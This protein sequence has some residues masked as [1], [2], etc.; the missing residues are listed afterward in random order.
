MC[1]LAFQVILTLISEYLQLWYFLKIQPCFAT[2]EPAYWYWCCFLS[3]SSEL[4][5]IANSLILL[6]LYFLVRLE[7]IIHDQKSVLQSTQKFF[8][9]TLMLF[10]ATHMVSMILILDILRILI[11]GLSQP[12]VVRCYLYFRYPHLKLDLELHLQREFR[13]KQQLILLMILLLQ[14]CWVF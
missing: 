7:F 5:V 10:L 6:Q 13:F 14:V 2:I 12:L 1:V 3:F 11:A 4:L 9:V 8:K